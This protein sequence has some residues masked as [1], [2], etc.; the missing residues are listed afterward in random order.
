MPP[1]APP[2]HGLVAFLFIGLCTAIGFWAYLQGN[3]LGVVH[4]WFWI[5]TGL[6]GI[7]LLAVIADN[8]LH[9]KTQS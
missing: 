8:L 2:Q 4:T 6:A 7:Y 5:G 9:H 3:D 1:N